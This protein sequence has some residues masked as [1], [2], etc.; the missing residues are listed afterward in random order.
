[1]TNSL[2]TT[3]GSNL[4]DWSADDPFTA[5]ANSISAPGMQGEPLKFSKGRWLT[6]RGKDEEE[7][8]GKI[9]V[10]DL[11]NLMIG[12]RRWFDKKITDQVVGLVA[13]KF[14][15]PSRNDLGDL[16]ESA[17]ER[18]ANGNAKDPWSLGLYL[19]L[20]DTESEESFAW[21]ATS[22]GAK[23]AIAELSRA[24]IKQRKKDPTR[25]VPVV[26]LE[27]D[28]YR[29]KDYGRVDTPKLTIVDWRTSDNAAAAIPDPDGSDDADMGD[30]IPF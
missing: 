23:K 22:F 27:A 14:R 12:W 18:D 5:L 4:V 9:L 15:P 19:R 16:D 8:G 6:G 13:E 24:F 30:T 10:A 3:T 28:F 20:V 29:H 11:D 1:M 2:T 25:C 26:K 7:A 17:W 21:A